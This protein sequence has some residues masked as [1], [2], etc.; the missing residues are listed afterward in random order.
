[1]KNEKKMEKKKKLKK[2]TYKKK[3]KQPKQKLEIGAT[4]YKVLR[5]LIS[6]W[7]RPCFAWPLLSNIANTLKRYFP[8]GL[9]TWVVPGAPG[10]GKVASSRF[11]VGLATLLR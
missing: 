7:S 6:G 10:L 5:S 9:T 8:Q 1:M 4:L 11:S 3:R 2:N